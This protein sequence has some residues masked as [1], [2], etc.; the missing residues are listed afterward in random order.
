MSYHTFLD[1]VWSQ[2]ISMP[3]SPPWRVLVCTPLPLGISIDLLWRRYSSILDLHILGAYLQIS[4]SN[5]RDR[6]RDI[7]AWRQEKNL[8][9]NYI[10]PA[11]KPSLRSLK[12]LIMDSSKP[13]CKQIIPVSCK[14]F[15]YISEKAVHL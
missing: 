13:A 4:R 7:A 1:F 8:A 2:K 15:I 12:S 9:V 6:S 10:F 11:E 3:P 14:N 5:A